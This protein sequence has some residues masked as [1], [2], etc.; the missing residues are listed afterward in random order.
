MTRKYYVGKTSMSNEGYE[1]EIIE[2]L[3]NNKVRVKFL[4]SH[5]YE[6][7]TTTTYFKKGMIKNPFHRSVFGVGFY[8]DG[9]YRAKE[10]GK[11]FYYYR[12]W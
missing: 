3:K 2:L 12:V 1:F 7:V 5:G 9:E 11:H 4:D 10:N 6:C 8:G